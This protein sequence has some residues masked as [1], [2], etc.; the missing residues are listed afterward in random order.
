MGR[1][2]LR[3]VTPGMVSTD[4]A[5]PCWALWKVLMLL[6]ATSKAALASGSSLGSGRSCSTGWGEPVGLIDAPVV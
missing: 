5:S 4:R 1:D 2:I 6:K 3:Q